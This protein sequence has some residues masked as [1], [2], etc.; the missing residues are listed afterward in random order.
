MGTPVQPES[1]EQFPQ[2]PEEYTARLNALNIVGDENEDEQRGQ[3]VLSF[4]QRLL[5]GTPGKSRIKEV[6]RSVVR[7]AANFA[8]ET[9]NTALQVADRVKPAG[10]T[11][12][13]TP[14]S[15]KDFRPVDKVDIN[16]AY[17]R[18]SDDPIAGFAEDATQFA[19]GFAAT[20]PIGGPVTTTAAKV[21]VAAGRGAIVDA[22]AFDPN[23][24]GLAELVARAPNEAVRSL[25]QA[26]SV[27]ADDAEL[28]K[29]L[30]RAAAGV[31]P[32]V[33][34]DALVAGIKYTW[35]KAVL[36]GSD[37][38]R[39]P[40]AQKAQQ[41]AA[42]TLAKIA[43]GEHVP[44][45]A[46]VRVIQNRDG[47]FGIVP[48]NPEFRVE[49]PEEGVDRVQ[50]ALDH[51][52]PRFLDRAE[53][54]AQA[55]TINLS[56]KER[57][58]A[59]RAAGGLTSEQAEE[60]RKTFRAMLSATDEGTL[61][62]LTEGTH[63]NFSYISEPKEVL[64]QIEAVSK[65]FK[66]ELDAAQIVD[67]VKVEEHAARVR[68]FLDGLDPE[69]APALMTAMLEQGSSVPRSIVLNA[70]DV[71]LRD[72]ATKAGK[73]F[74]LVEARPHD[75]IAWEEA[76]LAAGSL[77]KLQKALAGQNSETGRALK[78]L[79]DRDAVARTVAEERGPNAKDLAAQLKDASPKTPQE[80]GASAARVDAGL[81]G[82]GKNRNP[83]AKD[84]EAWKAYEE[85]FARVSDPTQRG[86]DLPPG[87]KETPQGDLLVPESGPGA[88]KSA[89]EEATEAHL[90]KTADELAGM[91]KREVLAV[92]RMAKASGGSPSKLPAIA[93]AARIV[94]ETGMVR[95]ALEFFVNA[96]LSS[97]VTHATAMT[98]NAM[99]STYQAA[100]RMLTGAVTANKPLMREGWDMLLAQQ[101]FLAENFQTA[102]MAFRQGHSVI[103]PGEVHVAIPGKA[104]EIIRTPSKGL[105]FVDEFT[106]VTNYRAYIYAKSLRYWRERGLDGEA[107]AKAVTNDLKDA[108]DSQTGVA[109]IPEAMKFAEVPTM[110]ADLGRDTFGGRL[111]N[112]FNNAVEAKFIAP[113]IKTSVNIFRYTF[114]RTPLLN[115]LAK[116]NRE[117]IKA[118]GEEAAVLHTQTF[119]ATAIGTYAYMQAKAGNI[120]GAGPKDPGLRHL[121][122]QDY[123]PYSIKINGEWQSYRRLDPLFT[124]LSIMADVHDMVQELGQEGETDAEDIMAASLAGIAAAFSNK[125]YMVGMTQFFEAWSGGKGEQ[126]K[127]WLHSFGTTFTTPQLVRALNDDPYLREV[128]SFKDAVMAGIPGLSDKLPARYNVFGE[129]ELRTHSFMPA[130]VRGKAEETVATDLL[131]LGRGIRPLNRKSV[132]GVEVDLTDAQRFGRVDGLTP[133]EYAQRLLRE[134]G[135]GEPSLR[136]ALSDLV[137]TDE[138]KEA[139][140]GSEQFPGGERFVMAYR[141]ID[142]Y[143][144][145]AIGEMLDKFPAVREEIELM[146][147]RKGASRAEGEAGDLEV[148]REFGRQ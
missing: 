4:W 42:E 8:N 78:F 84:S 58:D 20:A 101:M 117:I 61:R 138:W 89:A 43:S 30:K 10:G 147:A 124:P 128:E 37:T 76:R 72:I 77:V 140:A 106:R 33:A 24:A 47:T 96:A 97:P 18:R 85:E 129:P 71:V 80:I 34:L 50:S 53:A 12:I 56:M 91:T 6:G 70:A 86:S 82:G 95:R 44:E 54:E 45:G 144:R 105:L 13:L 48:N 133:Y 111:H 102:V 107:L 122:L 35:A 87:V 7:G 135:D 127:R 108:F 67:G 68:Q 100:S 74:D 94:Q 134:P 79:Q 123:K 73:L 69:Q 126:M 93:G 39:H 145:R 11:F 110:S 109:N 143:R 65:V 118:G 16:L 29:R 5:H 51:E 28:E 132:N 112:F 66:E 81:R 27:N 59:A 1:S 17:G 141:V 49:M 130:P 9:V 120:T 19:L 75:A 57:L 26:F 137:K 90:A 64:A 38:A 62:A 136:D 83:Y 148:L 41:E 52:G 21:A 88:G 32:G 98:M 14:G 104:G 103:R 22:V 25:G 125:S 46:H 113:F 31:V 55:S 92:L 139:S 116:R 23:D 115:M 15:G 99:V 114:D 36:R 2:T 131:A 142:A 146:Q 63:F 119:L 40:M 60:L 121:W 3:P